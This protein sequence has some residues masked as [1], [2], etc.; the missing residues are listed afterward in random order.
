VRR[1]FERV[2]VVALLATA[3]M[4]LATMGDAANV[5]NTI[6]V[7]GRLTTTGGSPPPA[8]T[9]AFI[10]KIFTTQTL[11]T[12]IWPAGVGENQNV[13]T[14]ANGL[15]TAQVGAVVPLTHAVFSAPTRWLEVTVNGEALSRIAIN[16]TPYAFRVAT[17]DG[18]DAQ[19]TMGIHDPGGNI[20]TYGANGMA[21]T[22][23]GGPATGPQGI[24]FVG[25]GGQD[26]A[27]LI[28]NLHGDPR[29]EMKSDTGTISVDPSTWKKR[30]ALLATANLN[31]GDAVY[32]GPTLIL[33]DSSA[34]FWGDFSVRASGITQR[35]GTD[36]ILA[37]NVGDAVHPKLGI[38]TGHPIEA[39]TVYGSGRFF[40]LS[41]PYE[42][43]D[44]WVG[45]RKGVVL[46]KD[47]ADQWGRS[48]SDSVGIYMPADVSDFSVIS[49]KASGTQ[50][51]LRMS[52]GDDANDHILLMPSGDVGIGTVAPTQKLTVNGTVYSTS[53]GF[54]FP[55]GSVQTTASFGGGPPSPWQSS[56]LSVYADTAG[57]DDYSVGINTTSPNSALQVAGPIATAF[58][59]SSFGTATL[60]AT[61]SVWVGTAAFPL[62]Q[63]VNLPT[64]VGIA[65]RQYT[66]KR[67]GSASV[68]IDPNGAQTIDG[69][70]TYTL[71][72]QWQYVVVVSNGSNWLIVGNN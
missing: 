23:S 34:G 70:A 39:L 53:G 5:P 67:A 32:M 9:K 50:T 1:S 25:G 64:A 46:A 8:G 16:T 30:I 55:D 37:I 72:A 66:I 15:W 6:A 51:T 48:S 41:S 17:I 60:G 12:E 54:K 18:A 49:S 69:A 28:D 40:P 62:T 42:Q 45:A 68:T 14:D 43:T 44:P 61:S 20:A 35:L 2:F 63:T 36:T 27:V 71:S 24:A 3:V 56:G 57:A 4:G 7:Q 11:G 29:F 19:D 26:T 10:F 52:V 31:V 22:S 38:H 65:G 13:T 47:A 33:R 21:F 59:S 58:T